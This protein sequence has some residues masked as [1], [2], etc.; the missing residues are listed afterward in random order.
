MLIADGGIAVKGAGVLAPYRVLDLTDERGLFA[1]LLF[2]RLGTD[3]IQIEPPGGSSASHVPPFA[4]DPPPGENSHFWS[5]Y[6]SGKRGITCSLNRAEGRL[7]F[8]RLVATADVLFESEGGELHPELHFQALAEINALLVHV[9]IS[10]FGADCPK[11]QWV[12]S[13]LIVWSAAG[14]LWPSRDYHG[15][16]L[17]ISAHKLSYGRSRGRTRA[18][19]FR[20]NRR[21]RRID[22]AARRFAAPYGP[23]PNGKSDELKSTMFEN[24]NAGKRGLAL[25]VAGRR[26]RDRARARKLAR[27]RDRIFCSR[28]D[29]T[30]WTRLR[31][32]KSAQSRCDHASTSLMGQVGPPTGNG[33]F[34][35]SGRSFRGSS[36]IDRKSRQTSHRNIR[37]LHRLCCRRH[38]TI[39][40]KGL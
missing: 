35:H 8:R 7:L 23:S 9:T 30:V 37:T 16:P 27:C 29:D 38:S 2:G 1:G 33:R 34:R 25:E 22:Q 11:T 26:P 24:Y 10:G 13:E 20:G 32:H 3:V 14:P 15:N 36:T 4:Q 12:D 39:E 17:R 19:R 28:T 18:R 31:K 6:A 5:A 21:L 40:V